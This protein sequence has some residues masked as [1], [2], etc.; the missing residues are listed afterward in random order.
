M[1]SVEFEY[2]INGLPVKVLASCRA[3][4][5]AEHIEGLKL[6]FLGEDDMRLN[7]PYDKDLFADIEDQAVYLLAESYYN[8]ELNFYHNH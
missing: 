2:D 7:I 3:I 1:L 5:E 6:I 4:V 8:P